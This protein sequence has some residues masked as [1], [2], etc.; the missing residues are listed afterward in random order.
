MDSAMEPFRPGVDGPWDR[1]AASHLR[2]RAGFRCDL[3]ALDAATKATPAKLV[4]TLLDDAPESARFRELDELGDGIAQR[5]DITRLAG[6]WLAR[7]V[8]TNA[9]LRSRMALFWH[10][11]FATSFNKVRNVPLLLGQLRTL[12]RH[13]LGPFDALLLAVARDPAMIVWLD[14][15]SNNKG[16]PNENF[17]RELLELFTLGVGNYS[18]RDIRETARAF[19]GWHQRGGRFHFA[20]GEHDDGSKQVLNETGRFDGTDIIAIV[21]RQPAAATF[22]AR[23]LLLEFLTDQPDAAAV[24]AFAGVL[25]RE[26]FH[27]GRALGTLFLSRAMFNSHIRRA[28]I[29]SPVEFV[30]GSARA[31]HMRLD[32]NAAARTVGELGQRLFEPP[33]VRGWPGGRTWIDSATMLVRMNAAAA[34]CRPRDNGIGLDA[35]ELRKRHNLDTP[36]KTVAYLID[37]LLDGDVPTMLRDKMME[38]ARAAPGLDEALRRAARLILSSPE[39]QLV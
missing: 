34:A 30:V 2:R 5:D 19:T 13:A 11:H 1:R 3:E 12:E 16:R 36:D 27:I 39:Y 26:Q 6:W 25:K 15:D 28:R 23:K 8:H 10:N 29:S 4:S 22:L 14:G 17:A 21:L 38:A 18:E 7:M 33:S 20:R 24:E 32:M 31:L 9:P 35:A 37:L